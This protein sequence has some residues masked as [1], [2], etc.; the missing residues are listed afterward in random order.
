MGHFFKKVFTEFVG[1]LLL[2]YGSVFWPQG[3]W[4]LSLP[5][6]YQTHT[7]CI[8]RISPNYWDYQGSPLISF[9]IRRKKKFRTE[10]KFYFFLTSEGENEIFRF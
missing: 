7:P 9:K 8:G 2:L 3:M 5:T 4:D 6:S 10:E 1:T